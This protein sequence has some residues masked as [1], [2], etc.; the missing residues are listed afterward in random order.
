MSGPNKRQKTYNYKSSW[1]LSKSENATTASFKIAHLL[2]KKK[3]PLQDVELL[4]EAFLAG[5]ERLFEGF[6]KKPEIISAIQELQLS[7]STVLRRI[8]EI[9]DDM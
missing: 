4:K 1:P 2:V 3:K 5:A 7:D 9:A 8:E 6:Y